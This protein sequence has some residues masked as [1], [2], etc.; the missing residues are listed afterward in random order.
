MVKSLPYHNIFL[1]QKARNP[2]NNFLREPMNETQK[3][4]QTKRTKNDHHHI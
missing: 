2:F 1:K 3:K 4:K